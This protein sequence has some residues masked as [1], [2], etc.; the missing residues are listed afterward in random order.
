HHA[1]LRSDEV[2]GCDTDRPAEPRGLG[3]D[4]VGG[5]N[6]LGTA[7]A[8]NRLH[9]CDGLKQLHAD[10]CGAQPQQQVE[11]VDDRVPVVTRSIVGAGLLFALCRHRCASVLRI[12][13]PKALTS[14]LQFPAVYFATARGPYCTGSASASRMAA[15]QPSSAGSTSL[16]G[17]AGSICMT[18]SVPSWREAR[19][20]SA[21]AGTPKAV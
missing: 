17:A 13:P 20:T 6:R 7:D 14:R 16:S 1:A 19:S 2:V 8:R 5:V 10:R 15:S 11:I 12:V 4:L 9:L 21:L 18:R 3:D